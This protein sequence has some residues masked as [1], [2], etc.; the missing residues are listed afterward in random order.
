MKVNFLP[1]NFQYSTN[2]TRQKRGVVSYSLNPLGCDAVTFGSMKKKEFGGIDFAVVEKFKAP[3]EKFNSNSDLQNW[4]RK[5]AETI[6]NKD[7]GGRQEETQLQRKA[8]LKEWSDYV[9]YENKNFTPPQATSLIITTYNQKERLALVLDSIKNL[10][11][12]PS[13]VLIADDGSREDTRVLIKSYA[14]DFPCRLKHIWQEDDG[15]RLSQIRNKAIKEA[16]NEYI[17]IIDGDMILESHFIADHLYF[18]KKG[19]FLQGSRVILSKEQTQEILDSMDYKIAYKSDDF[20]SKR[21]AL[22]SKCVYKISKLRAEVFKKKELVKGIRGCN[23]SFYKSD[24]EA[25]NGFNEDFI[26][27]G[28]ED[29]EFVAR[30]L[31]N[32]GELRRIKFNAIAYHLYHN[33][34]TRDMLESNHSIYLHTIQSQSTWCKNGINKEN[35]VKK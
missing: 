10:S 11:L 14:K 7:F 18:A 13:E 6:A 19:V 8:M 21:K 17:I 34:N 3:I 32:G 33:E 28:R 4:A 27:W 20:K 35:N 24:C 25:I 29:S 5:K 2:Q 23:M 9:L 15:F 22:L 16:Q 31:F 30:F 26:G 1:I 12:L